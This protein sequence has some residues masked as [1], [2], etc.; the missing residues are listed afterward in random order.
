VAQQNEVNPFPQDEDDDDFIKEVSNDSDSDEDSDEDNEVLLR[1]FEK[2]KQQRERED[3]K[4]W[5]K[6]RNTLQLIAKQSS[7]RATRFW[8]QHTAWRSV[9][10]RTLSSRIRQ[11]AYKRRRVM[12]TTMCVLNSTGSL[13]TNM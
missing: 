3:K 12:L 11:S 7:S 10:T 13:L 2:V 9:G 5:K 1:E 4:K 6:K 8:V